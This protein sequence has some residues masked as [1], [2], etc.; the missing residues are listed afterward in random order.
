M[1]GCFVDAGGNE[2]DEFEFIKRQDLWTKLGI[3][4]VLNH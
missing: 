2:A 3:L 1:N 4:Q